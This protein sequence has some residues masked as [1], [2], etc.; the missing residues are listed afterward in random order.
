MR[1]VKAC[2]RCVGVLALASGLKL[3]FMPHQAAGMHRNRR[4]RHTAVNLSPRPS[5][6]FLLFLLISSPLFLLP[7]ICDDSAL[8]PSFSPLE[9]GLLDQNKRK[10][11]LFMWLRMSQGKAL[12]EKRLRTMKVG[13]E[14]SQ[15]R[16]NEKKTLSGKQSLQEINS[17]A[18]VLYRQELWDYI[19]YLCHIR[20]DYT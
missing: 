19:Q 14:P 18:P 6:L 16:S 8:S 13:L 12:A 20:N 17:H 1:A 15:G 7:F 4:K 3:R 11:C 2:V 5:L 9:T 10:M